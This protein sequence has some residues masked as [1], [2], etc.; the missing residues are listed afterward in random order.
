MNRVKAELPRFRSLVPEDID[1]KFEFDQSVYVKDSI[2][3]LVLEGALGAL[4]T[5]LMVLVFLR[6]W[7]SAVIVLT[8]IPF[9]LLS[10]TVALWLTGQ[11]INIMT[12]GGLALAVGILV[13][14]AT[15]SIENIHTHLDRNEPLFVAIFEA[16]RETFIPRMLAMICVVAVFAPSLLMVGTTRALFVPLSLAVG[17]SMVASFLF[18]STLVPVLSAWLLRS[19]VRKE[20]T[21]SAFDKLRKRYS[22]NLSNS[23]KWN[24]T[25]S[26]AYCAI[27]ALVILVI[28]PSLG[29]ELFPAVDSGQF[30]I[31]MRAPTGTRVERT[32]VLALKLLDVIQQTAGKNNIRITLAF[33]GTVPS[34][35][36]INNIY[37]WTS[38]PQEAVL[39]V[40]LRPHSGVRISDLKEKLR[41][42]IADSIPNISVSFEAGD[43]VSQVMNFGAPT[44]VEI[45][46]SGPSFRR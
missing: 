36:P 20:G 14:E 24:W 30:Q 13:D 41:K 15:V 23:L 9:A 33:V 10:A 38:G 16:T 45:A 39:T 28:Y 40:A 2:L 31:R 35:Y 3:G 11:T 4:L 43:I 25:L 34:S 1:I 5:G 46:V 19:H 7:R 6:D 18:S 44:P 21:V 12:L 32:E 26:L 8:T 17:F 37:L 42:A 22:G 27:A 29:T